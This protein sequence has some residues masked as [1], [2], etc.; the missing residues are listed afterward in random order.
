MANMID[1][2]KWRGDLSFE[3]SPFNEIDNLILSELSFLDY[4][5]IVGTDPNNFIMLYDALVNVL[6]R[7]ED[8]EHELGMFVPA[9]IFALSRAILRSKR[10][11]KIQVGFFRFV[12]DFEKEIQF[13][14]ITFKLSEDIAYIAFRGTDDFIIGWKEDFNM[15]YMTPVPS[16]VE[17]LKYIKEIT[18]VLN[19]KFIVGGHSKGGN[20]SLYSTLNYKELYDRIITIYNNDGPGLENFEIQRTCL[21]NEKIINIIP[22]DSIIGRLFMSCGKTLVV[23]STAK[24]F[25]QHDP[26]TWKVMG[27]TF[28]SV[29]NTTDNSDGLEKA[30]KDLITQM[31]VAE[32]EKFVES[33]FAILESTGEKTLRSLSNNKG[34]IIFKYFTLDSEMKRIVRKFAIIFRKYRAI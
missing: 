18:S 16:Q 23:D 7:V 15:L 17:S 19:G 4:T 8:E 32:R 13:S 24:G 5:D 33:T 29:N 9:E 10:Y 30:I 6:E 14:A 12:L 26:F 34:K 27:N 1:Y 21:K 25:M 28:E 11:E 20:L 22:K 2:V 31:S 3:S